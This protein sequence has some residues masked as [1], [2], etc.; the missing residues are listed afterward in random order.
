MGRTRTNAIVN[1][2]VPMAAYW[3]R[4]FVGQLLMV[5]IVEAKA[6]SLLGRLV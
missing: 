4:R 1:V 6:N 2:A 3:Q 5:E